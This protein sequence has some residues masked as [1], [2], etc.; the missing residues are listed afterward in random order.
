[1]RRAINQECLYMKAAHDCL[2]HKKKKT[3]DLRREARQ[4]NVVDKTWHS[5]LVWFHA[6]ARLKIKNK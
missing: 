5:F 2:R 6:I 3:D 1:M 4:K